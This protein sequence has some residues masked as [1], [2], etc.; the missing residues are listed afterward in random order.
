ML[1]HFTRKT[2]RER[3]HNRRVTAFD[4]TRPAQGNLGR[5]ALV[6]AILA[7]EIAAETDWVEWKSV[8]ELKTKAWQGELA[9]HILGMANRDPQ[10]AR[11][12]VGGYGFTGAADG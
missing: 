6:Q 3:T 4:L 11:R 1:T 7:G 9:S 10:R 2:R 5:S 12:A 8:V